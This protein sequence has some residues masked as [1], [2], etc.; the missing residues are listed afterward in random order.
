L[1]NYSYGIL[2]TEG[3]FRDGVQPS[4]AAAKP[5]EELRNRDE[6][7]AVIDQEGRRLPAGLSCQL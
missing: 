3:V 5:D 2:I 7:L 1:G 6:E 4:P